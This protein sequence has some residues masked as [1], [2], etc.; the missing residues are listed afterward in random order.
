MIESLDIDAEQ[1]TEEEIAKKFGWEEDYYAGALI[2][3]VNKYNGITTGTLTWW[4]RTKP[5]MWSL[6]DE[7]FSSRSA[8]GIASISVFFV[9]TSIV[10]FCFKTHP[11][12]RIPVIEV[13]PSL[14]RLAKK[15]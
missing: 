4:Q 7:P 3:K 9:I 13:Y 10:S 1:P 5:K 14:S 11:P 6:F 12:L 2:Y 8:R 15:Q